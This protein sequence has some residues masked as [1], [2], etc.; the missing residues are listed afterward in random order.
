MSAR[1]ANDLHARPKMRLVASVRRRALTAIVAPEEHLHAAILARPHAVML[2]HVARLR[3][4]THHHVA[5]RPRPI[6]PLHPL[7]PHVVAW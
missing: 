7:P 2:L 5:R 3:T 6:R 1:V 4:P